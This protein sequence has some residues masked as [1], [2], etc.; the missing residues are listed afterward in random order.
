MVKLKIIFT[1]RT[2]ERKPLPSDLKK[3]RWKKQTEISIIEQ[4]ERNKTFSSGG[5][6]F[7]NWEESIAGIRDGNPPVSAYTYNHR[8]KQLSWVTAMKMLKEWM[9]VWLVPRAK[10]HLVF[11][12]ILWEDEASS[13]VRMSVWLIPGYPSHP[14]VSSE[15]I[16]FMQR[17]GFQEEDDLHYR[18]EAKL[19]FSLSLPQLS[20]IRRW[21]GPDA[22]K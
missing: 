11:S 17:L 2:G 13:R 4:C 12:E 19:R 15:S 22:N 18:T 1:S 8:I 6:F 9:V 21:M 16:R 7:L 20:S 10:C 5:G 3:R 14:L